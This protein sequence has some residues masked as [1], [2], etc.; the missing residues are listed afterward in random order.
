MVITVILSLV[1][2]PGSARTLRGMIHS[3]KREEFIQNAVLEGT[4]S[5]VIIFKYIIP[6]IASLLIVSTTL[7]IPG[8]IMSETTLSYLGLGINDPAELYI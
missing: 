2:W 5:L 3:I 8:F 6:Q 1:G 7:S 4:P